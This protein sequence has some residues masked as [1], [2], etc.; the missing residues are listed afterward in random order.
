MH[1]IIYGKL[2]Q[3]IT[4]RSWHGTQ[5]KNTKVEVGNAKMIE[6]CPE[7]K[8]LR[9][10]S[11][12]CCRDHGV[13]FDAICVNEG[14]SETNVMEALHGAPCTPSSLIFNKPMEQVYDV[15]MVVSPLLR[16]HDNIHGFVLEG[17]FGQH[18]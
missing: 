3:S 2:D 17:K 7:C 12:D 9:T 16:I 14:W 6:K 4:N 18:E 10:K 15:Y 1:A 13:T 5:S 8:P 11:A